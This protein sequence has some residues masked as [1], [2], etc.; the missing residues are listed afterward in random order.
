MRSSLFSPL[1]GRNYSKF[2][3]FGERSSEEGELMIQERKEM[4]EQCP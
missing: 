2:V 3:L 4:V 1:T